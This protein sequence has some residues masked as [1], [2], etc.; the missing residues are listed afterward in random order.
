MDTQVRHAEDQ[1]RYELV[2][3]GEVVG[4]ADYWDT[5]GALVFPHTE[6]D[7]EHRGKGLGEQLVQGALEDV[8]S[9]GRHVVPRC[10][11][12]REFLDAHPEF[13]DLRAA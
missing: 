13:A 3:D 5:G 2:L 10:W 12:V 6:I 9:K 4:I 7:P 11:F 1:G 8:R